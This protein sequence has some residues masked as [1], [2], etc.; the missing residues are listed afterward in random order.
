MRHDLNKKFTIL[1][2]KNLSNQQ[3]AIMLP[4]TFVIQFS[5]SALNVDFLFCL[6]KAK[7]GGDLKRLTS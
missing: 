6:S 7:T 2:K 3:T 4:Y 1:I 5:I